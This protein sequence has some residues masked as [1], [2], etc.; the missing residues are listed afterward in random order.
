[1]PK[2][3]LKDGT[4]NK[5]VGI[6]ILD[7]TRTD[8]FGLSSLV[9]NSS[10]LI[11]YWYQP[12]VTNSTAISL[13]TLSTPTSSYTSGGFIEIDPTNLVGHYRFDIPDVCLTG[14]TDVIIELSG[15]DNMAPCRLEIE[16]TQID[17]QNVINGGITALPNTVCTVNSSL[18]TSGTGMNQLS[19]SGGNI[20]GVVG[21]IGGNVDG[22]VG[23]VLGGVTVA[24]NSDKTGYILGS[25]GL[26]SIDITA[27]T[28]QATNFT[29]MMVA[30]WR[31]YFKKSVK[32]QTNLT[33]ITY[34]DDGTTV[35]TTQDYSD[36]GLGNEILESAG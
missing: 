34:A 20:A 35:I 3:S 17:N 36:D 6:V 21:N 31:R 33:I 13:I 25:T 24:T 22:S 10:G 26:N 11:A 15:A 14:S 16:L 23:S 30:L 12:G 18:I 2:I 29:Q 5:S 27:P 7:S 32:N 9:Y 4:I 28:G 8:D 1:M 19:V